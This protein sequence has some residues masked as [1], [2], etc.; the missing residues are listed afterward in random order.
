MKHFLKEALGLVASFAIAVPFCLS[1]ENIPTTVT[2]ETSGSYT[3]GALELRDGESSNYV[4]Y[5]SIDC[6]S[7]TTFKTAGLEGELTV[8][9][10]MAKRDWTGAEFL[11]V[12]TQS[13][14][15]EAVLSAV[16]V[17]DAAGNFFW[18]KSTDYVKELG[19][20]AAPTVGIQSVLNA[21]FDGYAKY[22]LSQLE[23]IVGE[24]T[25]LY[26]T[27]VALMQF[28]YYFTQ[29]NKLN[30][31]DVY[32]CV[33]G[34]Y[35]K[36]FAGASMKAGS[37]AN[38][39][40]VEY[41]GY[42][43]QEASVLAANSRLTEMKADEVKCYA[44]TR[45]QWQMFYAVIPTDISGYNGIS[46]YVDNSL[47]DGEVFFNKCL[48][49]TPSWEHWYVDGT[50]LYA[51][52]FPNEGEA[53][54]GNANVIP[55]G[56]K[57]RIVVPF[58]DFSTRENEGTKKN[59]ILEL[60]DVST[61]LEFAMD[62]KN[63]AY[64]SRNFL[65][66]EVK[67]VSD[68]TQYYR[69][70]QQVSTVG[71]VKI[72][73]PFEYK[74]GFDLAVDWNIQWSLSATAELALADNEAENVPGVAGKALKV[75]CGQKTNVADA[76]QDACVQWSL[77]EEQGNAAGARGVTYWIKNTSYAQIG[78]RFEFD[79]MVGGEAQRW[80][81]RANC[82][83]MLFDTKTREERM[84]MGK[85]GVY[86]PKNFEGYVRIEFTQFD[87][88][89]WVTV[90]GEF[91]SENKI[92][93]VYLIMN[94]TYHQGDS[95]LFDSLGWY[96]GDVELTTTFSTPLNNFSALMDSDYFAE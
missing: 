35:Q 69:T 89:S 39:Y 51:E 29:Q 78:F 36:V 62:T 7:V 41:N 64:T 20:S 8:T 10:N 34:E 94:S 88:P 40:G 61:R 67:L 26:E 91:S 52:Y 84:M 1:S 96:F 38:E 30:L 92:S 14:S 74:D 23:K 53:Y 58:S 48:R 32:I 56:F 27:N 43:K 66:R 86:I 82:R 16:K 31:G 68:A 5:S 55:A 44:N 18:L 80:Q 17:A 83:Y 13:V 85:S 4:E 63:N 93:T 76:N 90:G 45:S 6:L 59:G 28:T 9:L 33:S 46:Y 25:E 24:G 79:S 95:F 22:D 12:R 37:G 50:T 60:N 3:C 81:S 70:V 15:S 11:Y 2:A 19:A 47:S 49:E 21:N 71:D 72:V 65:I 54:V 42:G 75:T 73:N 87:R 77:N 57:G